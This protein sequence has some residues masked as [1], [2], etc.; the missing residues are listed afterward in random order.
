[1]NEFYLC[2]CQ[3]N[4][5]SPSHMI[6]ILKQIRGKLVFFSVFPFSYQKFNEKFIHIRIVHF[7]NIYKMG[8]F[9]F[10]QIVIPAYL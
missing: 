4:K 2:F 5:N 3:P 6:Y 7:K 8:F 9:V 1:M 10:L